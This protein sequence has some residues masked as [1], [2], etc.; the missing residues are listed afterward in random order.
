MCENNVRNAIKNDSDRTSAG[1]LKK[2][3]CLKC[4][5][6][7]LPLS[8]PNDH[9]SLLFP[10]VG[11]CVTSKQIKFGIFI[12]H[13]IFKLTCQRPHPTIE[14]LTTAFLTCKIVSFK[15]F[16]GRVPIHLVILC[17]SQS[18]STNISSLY[19]YKVVSK[20]IHSQLNSET[21]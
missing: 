20:Y 16:F 4:W 9:L 2:F 10:I 7:F 21:P 6:C 18:T 15:L 17:T 1:V 11:L 3:I 14:E 8:L 19:H 12:I 5:H 13:H